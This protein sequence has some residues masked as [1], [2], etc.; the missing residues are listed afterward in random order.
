MQSERRLLEDRIKRLFRAVPEINDD[1][2]RA[3]L[4]KYLCVLA[5]G[6][7]EVSCRDILNRYT[8]HRSAPS[9]QRF[10]AARLSDF[11][12][13]KVGNI[14]EL[15][16]CFDSDGASRWRASLSDEEADSIGLSF[17]VLVRYHKHATRALTLMEKEFPP[18]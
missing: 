13:A 2:L 18:T 17:D 5:S 15:L 4:T 3:E 10:V 11:Q 8:S 14:I 9:I 6:L 7:L 12:S 1:E 16:Q